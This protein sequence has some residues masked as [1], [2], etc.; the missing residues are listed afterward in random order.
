MGLLSQRRTPIRG[1]IL[2]AVLIL[3]AILG[4]GFLALERHKQR[5]EREARSYATEI[6][7]RVLFAHDPTY[8]RNNVSS[9]AE[10]EFFASR[11]DTFLARL[12]AAGEPARPITLEGEVKFE[13]RFFN[14]S[15]EFRA[16]L[17]FAGGP[18]VLGLNVSHPG[19]RWQIDFIGITWNFSGVR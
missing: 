15:A 12:V 14:P 5:M 19:S 11:Q 4:A 18:G 2:I 13:S 7:E 9:A 6:I 16:R 3:L 17:L 10:R 1:G 8:L